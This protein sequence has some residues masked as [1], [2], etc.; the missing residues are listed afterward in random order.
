VNHLFSPLTGQRH[1]ADM[2]VALARAPLVEARNGMMAGP[3]NALAERAAERAGRGVVGGS[4]AHTLVVDQ[5][6]R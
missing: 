5:F 6:R 3:T 4:D 2:Q 1:V